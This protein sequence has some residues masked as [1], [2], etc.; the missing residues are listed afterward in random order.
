[1]NGLPLSIFDI[2]DVSPSK[3]SKN[4][5]N[6]IIYNKKQLTFFFSKAIKYQSS[7]VSC[8]TPDLVSDF[9]WLDHV[10]VLPMLS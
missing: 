3:E 8:R 5:N 2:P 4:N 1:M 9:P 10:Q 6:N 7:A